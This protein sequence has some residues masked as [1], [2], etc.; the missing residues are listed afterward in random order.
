MRTVAV[1]L[2]FMLILMPTPTSAQTGATRI[3]LT[4]GTVAPDFTAS[5]LEGATISLAE[6]RGKVVVLNF[7]IT[8]YRDAAEHLHI[9]EDLN[10]RFAE[11][12]MRLVSISL[13]SGERGLADVR[14]LLRDEEIAHP[15][16]SDPQQVV[17]ALYGVRAL[18]AIFIIGRDGVI[19]HYHEGYTE[20][21]A[22]R[23]GALI[24]AALAV[25]PTPVA[26]ATTE[27]PVETEVAV[28]PTTLPEAAAGLEPTSEA[29]AVPE[30]ICKCFR[31]KSR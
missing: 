9:M 22:E 7:F 18:P 25:E 29:V 12:G 30:P 8:W 27:P 14:A 13:D 19:A 20:G 1:L 24:A 31:Q 23:L 28:E 3:P 4:A 2:A 10:T 6:M 17:A 5:T 21:D 11:Q 15:V 16:I 26:T